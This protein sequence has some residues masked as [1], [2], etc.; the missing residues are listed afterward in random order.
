MRSVDF[1]RPFKGPMAFG[2]GAL[3]RHKLYRRPRI[4]AGGTSLSDDPFERA[5]EPLP[6]GMD[7]REGA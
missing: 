7:C 4:S 3:R 2:G 1:D 6:H 5:G